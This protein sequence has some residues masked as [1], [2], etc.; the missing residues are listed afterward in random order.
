MSPSRGGGAAKVDSS[1]RFRICLFLRRPGPVEAVDEIGADFLEEL[2]KCWIGSRKLVRIHHSGRTEA[3]HD[4]FEPR[5]K[6]RAIDK[7]AKLAETVARR[8]AEPAHGRV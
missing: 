8:K 5:K 6:A 4:F 1:Q 7:R 2:H 3:K